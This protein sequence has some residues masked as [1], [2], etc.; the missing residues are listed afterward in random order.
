MK[1][2]GKYGSKTLLLILSITVAISL[3][4]IIF[5]SVKVLKGK[6]IIKNGKQADTSYVSSYEEDE[7]GKEYPVI[8]YVA[9]GKQSFVP[10]PDLS[11]KNYYLGDVLKAYY[12]EGDAENFFVDN[13]LFEK[14]SLYGGISVAALCLIIGLWYYLPKIYAAKLIEKGKWELCKVVKVEN[15]V[16]SR[17]KVHCSSK[18]ISK[19]KGYPFVSKSVRFELPKDIKSKTVTVYYLEKNP[20]IYYVDVDKLNYK[21]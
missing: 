12:Y 7:N 10:R 14:C 4:F 1:K 16:L 2:N 17:K 20:N 19:R 21:D 15:L 8:Y 3:V 18:G 5:G 9:E 11:Y 13:T 6:K